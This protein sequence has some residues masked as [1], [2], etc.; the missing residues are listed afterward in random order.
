MTPMLGIS[1]WLIPLFVMVGLLVLMLAFALLGR[2]RGGRYLRPVMQVLMK[3]PLLSSGLKKMSRAALERQ[4]PELASAVRKLER[5][6]ADK[7]PARAQRA[8]Q[9]LTADER[10][11]Y[12]A[13][14]EEQEAIP[15][16]VNRQQRRQLQK[17]R[18][19]R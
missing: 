1:L 14:V 6:N 12:M 15:A 19:R 3:V 5:A 17:A 7:D 4:N 18:K 8:L 9:Q 16:A 13:A 11:A 2:I 10:R